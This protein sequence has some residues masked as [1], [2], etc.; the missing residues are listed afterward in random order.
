[1]RKLVRFHLGSENYL[2]Q[3]RFSTIRKSLKTQIKRRNRQLFAGLWISEGSPWSPPP[4]PAPAFEAAFEVWRGARQPSSSGRPASSGRVG[5]RAASLAAAP[6]GSREPGAGVV[7]S[8]QRFLKIVCLRFPTN[9]P[10]K[11]RINSFLKQIHYR[12]K[13]FSFR[14]K[15][16]GII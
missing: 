9:V 5:G 7:M 4:T 8:N 12:T 16:F 6:V 2:L 1:M 15:I 13:T 11:N 14:S 3:N 10:P